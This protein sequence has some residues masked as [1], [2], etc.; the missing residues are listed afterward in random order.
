M[1]VTSIQ[2]EIVGCANDCRSLYVSSDS[3]IV[4]NII[5]VH[6]L[7]RLFSFA[8]IYVDYANTEYGT[9]IT[10]ASVSHAKVLCIMCWDLKFEIVF[11]REE[12]FLIYR[13]EVKGQ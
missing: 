4:N 1:Y 9:S 7:F 12:N 2:I 13:A 8:F 10:F 11:T 6:I 3:S 5:A